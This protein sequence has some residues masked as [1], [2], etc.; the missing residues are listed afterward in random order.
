MLYPDVTVEEWCRRYPGLEVREVSCKHCS[1]P[2]V[3][4]VPFLSAD[5]VGFEVKVCPHC[6]SEHKAATALIRS[7]QLKRVFGSK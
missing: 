2:F 5:F 6:G 7:N 4:N 3:I 1:L